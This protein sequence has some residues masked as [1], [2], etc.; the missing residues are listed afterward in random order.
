[1]LG[2]PNLAD[3][4]WLYG[5]DLATIEKT[6][7]DGRGGTMPAWRTRLDDTDARLIAAWVYAQSHAGARWS[8]SS[9]TALARSIARSD[10]SG[11]ATT[12]CRAL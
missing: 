5:G 9:M 7:R 3:A 11:A 2:A 8:C 12:T 1:M 10:S 4:T 6:I